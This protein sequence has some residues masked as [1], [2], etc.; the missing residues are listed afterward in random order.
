M[1]TMRGKPKLFST[2][3]RSDKVQWLS[4]VKTLHVGMLILYFCRYFLSDAKCGLTPSRIQRYRGVLC[5]SSTTSFW[6]AED[7]LCKLHVPIPALENGTIAVQ[8]MERIARKRV[9]MSVAIH[10][11]SLWT[12]LIF[13]AIAKAKGR[14]IQLD[15]GPDLREE[16]RTWLSVSSTSQEGPWYKARRLESRATVAVSDASS[17]QWGGVVPMSWGECPA[18][19]GFAHEWLLRHINGKY[20]FALLETLTECCRRHP[21]ELRRAQ[22]DIDV[23][24]RSVVDLR[25]RSHHRCTHAM[26][27]KRFE[28]QVTGFLTVAALGADSR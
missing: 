7:K 6:I 21:G 9:S 13:A 25:W 15:S 2:F 26:L 1:S 3:G 28:L 20:M 8:T 14:A 27:V 23:N 16:L 4:A 11:A 22:L 10:P 5:H 12:H 24:N 19:G 17:N 18:S